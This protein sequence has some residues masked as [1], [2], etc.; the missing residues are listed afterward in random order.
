MSN[1]ISH[2]KKE[3]QIAGWTDK[4]GKFDCPMQELMCT[5]VLELLGLFASHGHSGSSYGYALKIFDKLARFSL[6]KPLTGQEDEWNEVGDGVWQNNRL[7][8]VF[9][10]SEGKPYDID[11]NVYWEW[12][13][14]QETGEV[15][16][17]H[18]SKGGDRFYIEFPYE[19]QPPN[20]IFCPSEEFP[21]EILES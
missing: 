6:I 5:Q 8:S 3:F 2:A 7:S 16:K 18:F 12:Y 13:K 17:S 10:D 21:D 9:K 11:G 14:D 4:D 1:Y 20:E 15:Y 19:Q